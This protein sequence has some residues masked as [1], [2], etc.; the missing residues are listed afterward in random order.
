MSRP[1]RTSI[2]RLF[3]AWLDGT[4]E[5]M[6]FAHA[7]RL[8]RHDPVSA[9]EVVLGRHRARSIVAST[10]ERYAD[11][12]EGMAFYRAIVYRHVAPGG[13]RLWPKDDTHR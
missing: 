12:D 5:R 6:H 13:H 4:F 2:E 8:A 11:A 3:W 7:R 1:R 9:L 10:I